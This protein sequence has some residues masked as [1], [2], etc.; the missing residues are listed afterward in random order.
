M[1][2][3][4]ENIVYIISGCS[5]EPQTC[6]MNEFL[7]YLARKQLKYFAGLYYVDMSNRKVSI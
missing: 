4:S 6:S 1:D 3:E 2:F 5:L 7:R